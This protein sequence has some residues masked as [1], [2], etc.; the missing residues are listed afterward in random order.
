MNKTFKPDALIFDADGVIV[1]SEILWDQSQ[2]ILLSR[3][4]LIYDRDYLKPKLAGVTMLQGAEILVDYYK[5]DEDPQSLAAERQKLIEQL[6]KT[7]IH[8]ITG[9]SEFLQYIDKIDIKYC[10]ATSMQKRLM[11]SVN[12]KLH[13][14]ELFDN[15]IYHTEDVGNIS[16]PNPDVFLFAAN[17][18][19]IMP[20][21]CLVIEDS[22]HGIEAAKRADMHVAGLATTFEPAI[23]N[24]ADFVAL[25]FK[26]LTS[27]LADLL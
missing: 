11:V 4:K 23:L 2:E 7:D 14:D 9:F 17:K 24:Q 15:K 1:D 16:K 18:L 5:I 19:N 6:F 12:N 8:F 26:H 22:P 20:E 27:Y 21:K 3:R 10:I 13:L 25:D